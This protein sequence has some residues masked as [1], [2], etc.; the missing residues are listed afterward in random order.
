ME[1]TKVY[2]YG[3]YATNTAVHQSEITFK[4]TGLG[5]IYYIQKHRYSDIVH[6]YVS[7]ID[8]VRTLN[9]NK[10]V[11]IIAKDNT[12]WTNFELEE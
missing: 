12:H 9:K 2:G 6:T 4:E 10:K 7:E 3:N 8:V 11:A 5:G 1:L